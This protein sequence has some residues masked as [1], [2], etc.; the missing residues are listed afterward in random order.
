MMNNTLEAVY[1]TLLFFYQ[2]WCW[3]AHDGYGFWSITRRGE[4]AGCCTGNFEVSSNESDVRTSGH[5]VSI[6]VSPRVTKYK[7]DL[8]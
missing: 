3:R 2:T 5:N 7:F 1:N 4:V 6:T 8:V